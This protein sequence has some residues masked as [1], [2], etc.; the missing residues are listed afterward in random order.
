MN[1]NGTNSDDLLIGTDFEDIINGLAGRDRLEGGLGSDVLNG[2]DGNDSG[3][4]LA[5]QIAGLFGGA[6]NDTL[7]GEA[8]DDFLSPSEGTYIVDG[9]VGFDVLGFDFTTAATAIV[10]TYMK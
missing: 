3:L 5:A 4:I 6:G 10:V 1:I 9:G 2:G 8:G 7:N